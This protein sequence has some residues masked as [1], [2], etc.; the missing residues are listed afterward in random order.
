MRCRR[1]LTTRVAELLFT[2][3]ERV[4]RLFGSSAPIW[5]DGRRLHP[6]M[7]LLLLLGDTT[8]ARTGRRDPEADR[9]E[10]RRLARL[11]SPVVL[12][13]HVVD[14]ELPGPD[15]VVPVRIYRPHG[16]ES[17]PPLV[18]YAHGGGFVSGDLDTHDPTCRLLAVVSGCVVVA[19]HYRRAPEHPF[20]A[21]VDDLSAAYRW[22]LDHA[23]EL[24]ADPTRVGVMG[25]SAGATLSAVLCLEA[26]RLGWPQPVAQCL[27]YP[28]TDWRMSTPS[29]RTFADGFGLTFD[30]M[31]W[32]RAQY[33]P[34]PASWTDPR[35]SPLLADDH[36]GLAPAL[37]VTAGFDPLRDDGLAYAAALGADGVAVESW[38]YDDFIHAFHAMLVVP[39]AWDA[40]VRIARRVGELVRAA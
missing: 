22:V 37:V 1:S 4:L 35:V 29:Y 31:T 9:A 7:Q 3:P 36:A 8:G 27:V 18:L 15:A 12:D 21:A 40:A 28:L 19:V 20:P 14:R 25:D 11:F 34:D 10:T 38:C 23:D 5:R 26:R 39:D 17:R 32:F 30:S 2:R 16:G 33:V 24:A 13:V 6:A